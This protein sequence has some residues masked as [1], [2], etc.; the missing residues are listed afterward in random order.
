MKVK[1]GFCRDCGCRNDSDY[2]CSKNANHVFEYSVDTSI[3]E[4]NFKQESDSGY[5]RQWWECEY[6]GFN[7]EIKPITG[8]KERVI[9]GYDYDIEEIDGD[10]MSGGH[11]KCQMFTGVKTPLVLSEVKTTVLQIAA[12]IRNN[13][14]ARHMPESIVEE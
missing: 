9:S 7:I 6:L 2:K 12:L 13:L 8:Y 10:F 1:V 11:F 14:N 5:R 4:W 3:P